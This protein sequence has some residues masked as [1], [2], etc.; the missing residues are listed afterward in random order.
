M[1]RPPGGAGGTVDRGPAR[2]VIAL[3]FTASNEEEE[4]S[5]GEGPLILF[6][7]STDVMSAT[8]TEPGMRLIQILRDVP[9]SPDLDVLPVPV[10][11][12]R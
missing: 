7:E 6:L 10:V 3:Y 1:V 2:T 12:V 11:V 8:P 5:R 4:E 9:V